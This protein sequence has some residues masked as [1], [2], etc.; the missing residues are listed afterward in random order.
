MGFLHWLL[1]SCAV[2]TLQSSRSRE[3]W[4]LPAPDI[5]ERCRT[6]RYAIREIQKPTA[7]GNKSTE[8]PA[9]WK[10][11]SRHVVQSTG[12]CKALSSIHGIVMLGIYIVPF[13][14]FATIH[15]YMEWSVRKMC[16]NTFGRK[17]YELSKFSCVLS[18]HDLCARAQLRGNVGGF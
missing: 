8:K 12:F 9:E 4:L 7:G 14:F 3:I 2:A 11:Q 13:N 1:V 15:L 10:S 16:K 17:I 6:D 5:H 18:S